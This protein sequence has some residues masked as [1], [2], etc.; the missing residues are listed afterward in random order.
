M[1]L[2]FDIVGEIPSIRPNYHSSI[3]FYLNK[4]QTAISEC[5]NTHQANMV[6]IFINVRTVGGL[7]EEPVSLTIPET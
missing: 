3:C 7:A 2:P 1:Q 5:T 4:V 6:L